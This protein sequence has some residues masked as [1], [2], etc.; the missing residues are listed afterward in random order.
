MAL[1][2]N[3]ETVDQNEANTEKKEEK[4]I[5]VDVDE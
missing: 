1:S 3:E 5:V 2:K 4:E